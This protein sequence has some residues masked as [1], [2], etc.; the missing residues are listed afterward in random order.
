MDPG[1]QPSAKAFGSRVRQFRKD[2]G[3][4][5]ETLSGRCGLHPKYVGAIERGE[6]SISLFNAARVADGFGLT[7]S[8]LTEGLAL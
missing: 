1:R 6:K 7:L 4:T 8:D 2:R 3:W 5:I